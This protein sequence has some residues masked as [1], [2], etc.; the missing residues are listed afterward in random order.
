MCFLTNDK[1][2]T[3]EGLKPD[4]SKIKAIVKTPNPNNKEDLKRFI[5]MSNYLYK[6]IPNYPKITVRLFR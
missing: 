2:I 3:S 1:K 4:P 5:G 6:L